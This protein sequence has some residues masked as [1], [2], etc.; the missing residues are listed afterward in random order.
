MS[1]VVPLLLV[2][3][4]AFIT[5]LTAAKPCCAAL[6]TEYVNGAREAADGEL[7]DRPDVLL[8]CRTVPRLRSRVPDLRPQRG[9]LDVGVRLA[10]E[11]DRQRLQPARRLRSARARLRAGQMEA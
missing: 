3:T 10:D 1:D 4:L 6:G 11:A 8:D 2:S 9:Q 5:Q 7:H